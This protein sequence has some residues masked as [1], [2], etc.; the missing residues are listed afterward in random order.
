MTARPQIAWHT[1]PREDLLPLFALAEDSA[2]QLETYL[3]SGRVLVALDDGIP[4]GHLQLLEPDEPGEVEL[5]SMAVAEGRQRE[6]IGRALVERACAACRADG[7]RTLLVGTAT[8][9]IG[10]LR[11]YQ[12]LGFRMSAIER[13]VFTPDAGYPE[14]LD[15]DGIPLRDRVWLTLAL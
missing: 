15:V 10:N 8:A 14:G 12:R 2:T 9:D 6:G 1:G 5:R 13:D 11:F 4:V 3:H 7:A